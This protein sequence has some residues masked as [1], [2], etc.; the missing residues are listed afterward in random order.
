MQSGTVSYI[1]TLPMTSDVSNTNAEI[2][3]VDPTQWVD[4][5]GD[6]LFRYCVH[7]LRDE[8]VAEDMVQETLLAA[9]QSMA[10]YQGRAAERTWLTGILKHKIIDHYRRSS[11]EVSFDPSETDLSEFD[12]LFERNDEFRDRKS[13]V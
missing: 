12:P 4:D 2:A 5:H 13:V 11:R 6:Y 8:A 3:A 9:I 1:G 7:R 10:G